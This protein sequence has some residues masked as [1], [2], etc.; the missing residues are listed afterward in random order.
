MR[1][2]NSDPVVAEPFAAL[3]KTGLAE[4]ATDLSHSSVFCSAGEGLAGRSGS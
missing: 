2:Q 3:A 1:T 4:A